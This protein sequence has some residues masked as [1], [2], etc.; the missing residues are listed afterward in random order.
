VVL[1]RFR[2]ELGTAQ[3]TPFWVWGWNSKI[4]RHEILD[5]S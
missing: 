1:F 3:K 4:F 2:F 5:G